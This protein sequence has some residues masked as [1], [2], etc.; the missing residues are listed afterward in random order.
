[1]AETGDVAVAG[2]D[3]LSARVAWLGNARDRVC[4]H[5]TN[6]RHFDFQLQVR[7]KVPLH[8]DRNSR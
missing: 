1:M 5:Q 7:L 4:Q 8:T 6:A 3:N 2:E